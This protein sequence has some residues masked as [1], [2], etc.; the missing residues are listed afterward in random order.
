MADTPARARAAL[1]ESL[2]ADVEAFTPQ[3]ELV[4]VGVESVYDT[5]TSA[6]EGNVA[7]TIFLSGISPTD[8]LFLVRIYCS[9]AAGPEQAQRT[10]D[11]VIPVVWDL[12]PGDVGPEAWDIGVDT[13]L[14][15][16]VG[17]A[18]LTMGREDL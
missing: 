12:L 13:D 10:L 1:H 8:W 18:D 11:D 6:I 2:C 4:E 17:Q 9:L 16:L 7:I 15:A 3:P 5:E 14:N